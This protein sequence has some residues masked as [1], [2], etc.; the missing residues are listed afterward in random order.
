M[1]TFVFYLVDAR[2]AGALDDI[3]ENE[4]IVALGIPMLSWLSCR[5]AF[6]FECFFVIVV[7]VGTH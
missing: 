4:D 6:L 5:H 3:G 1:S 2:G 7:V